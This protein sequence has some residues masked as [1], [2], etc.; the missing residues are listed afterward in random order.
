M[1][2]VSSQPDVVLVQPPV[3]GDYSFWKSESLGMGYLA[4]FLEQRGY[5]VKIIDAFLLDLDVDVV[6]DEILSSPPR[7]ILG[8][9]MLS[10]ELYRTGCEIIHRLRDAGLKTHVTV[11][12][13]FATFWYQTMIEE[14]CPFDSIVLSEGERSLGALADFLN[15]GSWNDAEDL[16]REEIGGVLV[17][18]QKATIADLDS[19]PHPRRDYLHH[20]YSRYHLATVYTARGCGHNRC[21]FCSVRE[22]YRGGQCHRLRSAADVVDEV[23]EIAAQ[24]INFIFFCDEDFLGKEPDGPA[25]AIEIFEGI[26]ARGLKMRYTFNCT[27]LGV[28]EN[29]FRRLKE[30]GLVAVYIGIESNIDRMLKL[31]GKGISSDGIKRA[32]AI[33]R[34]LDI[35]LVP[36]WIMFD[37]NT[38]LEEIESQ[39]KFI[40]RLGAYHVNYIKSLYVMKGTPI[41]HIY[42]KELYRSHYYTGYFFHDPD[43]ELLVRILST[44]YL[45]TALSHAQ[46]IYPIW[47]RLLAG[48]GSVEEKRI[49]DRI[50]DTMRK[51][52]L[53]M[54]SEIIERIRSRTLDGLAGAI[55]DSLKDWKQVE[56]D[57]DSLARS[58]ETAAISENEEIDV[59]ERQEMLCVHKS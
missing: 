11:G 19:L 57:I 42:D 15:T 39:I 16:I 9:S 44:E 28:E 13:W 8:F 40:D 32:V 38:T 49:Y 55:E 24:G 14:G 56:T 37:R 21:T 23:A 58:I 35:K 51:L 53:G 45:P 48:Y 59:S 30:L 20:A 22:F 31:F 36:G 29:L 2:Q 10:Y 4:A 50:N 43:V 6:V 34:D 41:E 1:N 54:V 25:R 18:R 46:G 5:S 52:S 7:L 17:L 3:G 26:A 47:H 33:L 27:S 12:S